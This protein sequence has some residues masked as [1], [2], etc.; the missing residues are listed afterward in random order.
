MNV[1]AP[2]Q[3]LEAESWPEEG[4][5]WV[6]EPRRHAPGLDGLLRW[7]Y[8]IGASR[9][10]F[11]TGKPVQMRV[12]GRNRRGSREILDH[13]A[14]AE[15]TNHLYGADGAAR[16]QGGNDFDVSY[17]VSLSR[18]KQLRFRVNAT[19][20]LT[21][22][23][24]GSNLVLRPIPDVPPS[25]DEQRVEL[26]IRAALRPKSGLV[27]L[28]G[29][30]GSGKSTLLAGNK[31][32]M[33]LDP[34]FHGNIGT[35]EAPVEYML[36]HI[37]SPS[38]STINQS[39]IPRNLPTFAAFVRGCMRREFT[40]ILVGECRDGETMAGALQAALTGHTLYTTIHADDV[41]MT[42]QRTI[43]LCPAEERDNLVSALAQTLRLIVNQR[44]IPSVDGK[45]T[46]IREYL[47]FDRP[48]RMRLLRAPA[49][50]WPSIVAGAVEDA[51]QTF[52]DSIRAALEEGRISPET[53]EEE[54]GRD[55]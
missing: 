5:R 28:S 49:V 38:G 7:A 51:R 41:A 40:H 55:A 37:V 6:V 22:S 31:R 30:T 44:L 45:R 43:A 33:L 10:A 25:L 27:F 16:L 15:I 17:S 36:E 26:G 39:E 32:E 52:G 54:L 29:A 50:E 18:I 20:T 2:P 19:P 21:R 3:A 34:N 24:D 47:A 11:Q 23:G 9:V 35:G 42:I 46:A 53:A 13:P 8:E 48:L 12:H 4:P 1:L 14:M